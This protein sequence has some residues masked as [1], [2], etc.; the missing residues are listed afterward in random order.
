[1]RAATDPVQ[2]WRLDTAFHD[3]IVAACPNA[4]LHAMI[5]ALRVRLARYEL[6][7]M[8]TH[9]REGHAAPQHRQILAALGDADLTRAGDL[10]SQNWEGSRTMVVDW[11]NGQ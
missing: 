8:R 6:T 1:L 2:R 10:L 5:N 3:S 11:L 4:N 7:F 9:D